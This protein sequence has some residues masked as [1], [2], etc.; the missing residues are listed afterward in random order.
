MTSNT[1]RSVTIFSGR[2]YLELTQTDVDNEISRLVDTQRQVVISFYNTPDRSNSELTSAFK[3]VGMPKTFLLFSAKTTSELYRIYRNI[4]ILCNDTKKANSEMCK[5]T[6]NSKIKWHESNKRKRSVN[7]E[8]T[9]LSKDNEELTEGKRL[10]S[11]SY[12]WGTITFKDE[13][14]SSTNY[15]HTNSTSLEKLYM[16]YSPKTNYNWITLNREKDFKRTTLEKTKFEYLVDRTIRIQNTTSCMT[17]T[18]VNTAVRVTF[19]NC[20]DSADR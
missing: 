19:R 16:Y 12:A 1:S 5:K 6:V 13:I 7:N 9:F 4:F 2:A 10:Y 14:D 20:L 15:L 18:I 8:I 3:V 17:K 11:I